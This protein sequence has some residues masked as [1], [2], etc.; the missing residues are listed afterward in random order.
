MTVKESARGRDPHHGR[1]NKR[2]CRSLRVARVFL[3]ALSLT[4]RCGIC[5]SARLRRCEF[6]FWFALSESFT[7][8]VWHR[9]YY[10]RR[11][12]QPLSFS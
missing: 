4:V 5:H 6:V 8:E 9:L 2:L 7:L 10:R 12:L 1:R 11:T 3:R